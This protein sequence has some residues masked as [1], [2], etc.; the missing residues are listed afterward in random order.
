MVK[1][2]TVTLTLT[3]SVDN[4]FSREALTTIVKEDVGQQL[5]G[6]RDIGYQTNEIHVEID[7]GS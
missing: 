1:L 6:L 2:I 5:A 7:D 4:N 3:R